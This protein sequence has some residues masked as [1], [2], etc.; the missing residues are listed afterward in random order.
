MTTRVE[1]HTASVVAHGLT[2]TAPASCVVVECNGDECSVRHVVAGDDE[3]HA[4]REVVV[5]GWWSDGCTRDL[6][7]AC[8]VALS[9]PAGRR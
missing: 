1:E 6:C 2:L 5:A 4:T 8:R 7:P 3:V 9:T